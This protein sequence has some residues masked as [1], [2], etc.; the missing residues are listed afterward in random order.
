MLGFFLAAIPAVQGP[1][2]L[3]ST[4]G[5][6]VRELSSEKE[7]SVGV[8]VE[9]LDGK[10]I[11]D[12]EGE[13]AFVLASNTKILTTA[14]ALLELGSDFRWHTRL[15]LDGATLRVVGEGDPSLR[16]LPESHPGDAFLD[17]AA[18]ALDK[19]GVSSLEAIILDSRGIASP[20]R[21]PLWPE[22]QWQ[23]SYCAPVAALVVEGGCLEVISGGGRAW[24]G[25]SLDPPIPVDF[26]HT[27]K[28]K[29]LSAWWGS[30]GLVVRGDLHAR[31]SLRLAVRDPVD[32]FGRWLKAGLK[33]RGIPCERV[34]LAGADDGQENGELI[35][36]HPSAWKLADAVALANLES[37][38]F[39]AELL[40]LALG[41]MGGGPGTAEA[42]IARTERIL[43]PLGLLP[44]RVRQTDGSGLARSDSRPV[45]KAAPA[46]L[47]AV[48]RGMAEHEEG[49]CFF[50][51]LPV[52]GVQGRL[53]Q[54]FK[55]PLF[56][57][58]RVHAKTGWIRGASSLSGYLLAGDS[59]IL[60][61]S[62]VVNYVRDGTSRTHNK[63][64]QAFQ[65]FVLGAVL[66]SRG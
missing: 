43:E 15:R 59:E 30:K 17:A 1:A 53:A 29:P 62:I 37:D 12:N 32:I 66:A 56:Q 11:F 24:I 47:C 6:K 36:S 45:N 49:R 60:V 26:R 23:E 61:F 10:I 16:K 25:P 7:I 51:S 27:G 2:E 3:G 5:A 38:N 55:D 20:P 41:R 50:R 46:D 22:E 9:T 13:K 63:R 8:R 58:Q 44:A 31:D 42:G 64:F 4:L 28:G 19:K 14:A 40:L 21:H 34:V 39:T 48:L 65:E 57:P 35:L 33:R 18:R 52:G 54:R